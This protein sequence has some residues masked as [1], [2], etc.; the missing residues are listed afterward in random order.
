MP[1]AG[2][3]SVIQV[4]MG[5]LAVPSLKGLPIHAESVILAGDLHPSRLEI[6]DGLVGPSVAKGQFP[7]FRPQSEGQ[8]L[9]AKA[10]SEGRNL[11]R[12]LPERFN[13]RL[14][15]RR[16]ARRLASAP[17]GGGQDDATMVWW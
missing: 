7:G 1:E 13:Q 15:G 8:K 2:Y 11:P 6:A 4:H 9:V 10:D 3:R 14:D 12:N 17:L 16:I 5:D